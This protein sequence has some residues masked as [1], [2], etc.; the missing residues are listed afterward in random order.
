[1]HMKHYIIVKYNSQVTDRTAFERDIRALFAPATA[2]EGVREVT[3]S[4]AVILS[5]TRHDLMIC[6]DMDKEALAVFDDSP[7]HKQWK[8]DFA[9]F[10]ETKTIFDCD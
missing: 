3:V 7:I 5:Q 9:R 4:P 8:D 2:L 10:I 1:M 6:I